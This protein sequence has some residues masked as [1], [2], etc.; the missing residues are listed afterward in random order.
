MHSALRQVFVDPMLRQNPVTVQV[1][2]ICAALAITNSLTSSLIMSV[3][4]ATVLVVSNVSVSLIR[5]QLPSSVRL[6]VQITVIASAVT[7]VDQVLAAFAPEA[8]R[9]LTVYVSLIVTNCIVL[10]R[11]ESF[12][13]KHGVGASLVDA[14]GNAL[15]YSAILI[16][17]AVI[18]EGLGNGTLMGFPVLP[19]IEQGGWYEPIGLFMLAPSAFFIIGLIVWAI[20]SRASGQLEGQDIGPRDV[21][22]ENQPGGEP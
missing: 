5:R 18:R 8:S 17:V 11:A 2:G 7:V 20:R 9:R 13:M 19:T 22:R 6:I 4:M 10:G 14:V 1:L 16:A 15:G 21:R 3:A 12:A